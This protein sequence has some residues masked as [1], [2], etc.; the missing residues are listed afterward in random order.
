MN[1]IEILLE[2]LVIISED[3]NEEKSDINDFLS[4]AEIANFCKCSER[5]LSIFLFMYLC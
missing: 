3:V 1:N 5:V 4:V 2:A